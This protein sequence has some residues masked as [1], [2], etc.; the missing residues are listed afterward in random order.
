VLTTIGFFSYGTPY[1]QEARL[2]AASLDRVKMKY[3]LRG[4]PDRG[5][6]YAN[7]AAKAELIREARYSMEGP[8]LYV[9]VDA[10]VHANCAAYFE[11]L[12][13]AGVDFGVHWFAG[14][15]KGKKRKDVCA[16]VRQRPCNRP[17]RLLSGTL[18]LGDTAPARNLV[19]RWVDKNA[20]LRRAGIIDAGGQKNLWR[21][22]VEM[23]AEGSLLMEKIPGRYCIV[24]D[25]LFAYPPGER[26]IIEHTIASRENRDV[27]GRFNGWRQRR[28]MELRQMV[29]L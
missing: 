26:T 27:R 4:F 5:D 19:D 3:V 12:A 16:C 1:E 2:L 8:L 23:E 15:S 17:H 13:D 20:E 22:V 10:C 29:G 11:G 18:F 28:M 9:D 25:K 14:P 6:W 7:T 21:V 24:G